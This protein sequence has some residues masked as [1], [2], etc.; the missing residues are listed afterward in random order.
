MIA[1]GVASCGPG[2]AH[3]PPTVDLEFAEI[4]SEGTT[5]H[6]YDSTGQPTDLIVVSSMEATGLVT[7]V[8]A[9]ENQFAFNLS[10]GD[11]AR[12]KAWTAERIDR[13]M[14]VLAGDQV[15]LQATIKGALVGPAVLPIP[16]AVRSSRLESAV[17]NAR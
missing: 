11:S 5:R 13:E 2:S 17:R 10:A 9:G 14:A 1:V 15:L 3:A 12:F 4:G 7:G 6:L 16:P 8:F